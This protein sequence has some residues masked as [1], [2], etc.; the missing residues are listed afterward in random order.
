MAV[1]GIHF[2]RKLPYN[3]NFSGAADLKKMIFLI[4]SPIKTHVKMGFPIVALPTA[5][6]LYK[7]KY[8]LLHPPKKACKK[9][10]V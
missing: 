5:P 1:N 9:R 4:I 6:S 3:F 2:K 10:S 7:P 8:V